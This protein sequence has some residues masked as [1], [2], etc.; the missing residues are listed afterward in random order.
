MVDWKASEKNILLRLDRG[1]AAVEAAIV[2]LCLI[3]GA[4]LNFLLVVGRY[5]LNLSLSSFEEISVY[6]ILWMTFVGLVA[7]DRG[8]QHIRIDILH[9]VVTDSWRLWLD[10]FSDLA[11]A[12]VGLTLAWLSLDEVLFSFAIGEQAVTALETPIWLVMAIMPPAFLLFGLRNLV[13]VFATNP[14]APPGGKVV[15]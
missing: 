1:L 7:A 2:G 5:V 6:L 9:H 11:K 10:R 14:T 8:R 12:A 13:R 15:E 3:T 4:I